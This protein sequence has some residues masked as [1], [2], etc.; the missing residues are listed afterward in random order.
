MRKRTHARPPASQQETPATRT[1]GPPQGE[2][3]GLGITWPHHGRPATRQAPRHRQVPPP[4][5][6]HPADQSPPSSK[7]NDELLR[8]AHP[9]PRG[10]RR[11]RSGTTPGKNLSSP[12]MH[13]PTRSPTSAAARASLPASP[14]CQTANVSQRVKPQP[15]IPPYRGSELPLEDPWRSPL[16][17]ADPLFKAGQR[18]N[19]EP[20]S[21]PARPSTSSMRRPGDGSFDLVQAGCAG[22]ASHRRA[23]SESRQ[24]RDPEPSPRDRHRPADWS[25]QVDHWA[26]SP[27]IRLTPLPAFKD[28]SARHRGPALGRRQEAARRAPAAHS[29]RS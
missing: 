11:P 7:A 9:T 20:F 16:A 12:R 8:T 6:P 28:Q 29:R 5:A 3:P 1:F 21:G 13:E 27:A 18:R 14:L 24:S 10:S 22:F 25:L 17:D 26:A 19:Q 15:W 4:M 2:H 23:R